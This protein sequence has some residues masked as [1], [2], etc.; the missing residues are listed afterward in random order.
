MPSRRVRSSPSGSGVKRL[1]SGAM[2]AGQSHRSAI[3]TAA[4]KAKSQ[5]HH[6]SP[7]YRM[8]PYVA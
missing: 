8:N 2:N 6:S 1:K 4:R 3:W 5:T 7:L